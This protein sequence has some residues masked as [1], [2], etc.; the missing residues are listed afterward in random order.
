[1]SAS[2]PVLQPA[3]GRVHSVESCGAVDGPGLRY[4]VF[5]QGCLLRC[6]YCHNPDSWSLEGG[7]RLRPVDE[8]ARQIGSVRGFI[9]GVTVTGGEPLLQAA[10]V[11][12][13]FRLLRREGLHTA[14]DTNGFL[15]NDDVEELLEV[16]DLVLL[17]LKS[18]DEQRHRRVAGCS[19]EPIL[20]F[21]RRLAELGK[22]TW[23]RYVLVPGW[24]DDLEDVGHLAEFVASLGPVVEAVE[25]LPFHKLGEYKW[26]SLGLDYQLNAVEP[27]TE[28]SVRAVSEQFRARGLHVR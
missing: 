5:L 2:F 13:L 17:D 18:F 19:N 23:I 9:K 25:V 28:A 21:A 6:V 15:L 3:L 20:R 11:A 14:L 27:P 16:T 8:L 26:Q 7:G 10:Y 24:T 12:E 22:K 1:M 4:V